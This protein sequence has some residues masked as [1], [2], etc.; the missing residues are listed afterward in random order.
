M[1]TIPDM[2]Y[3]YLVLNTI[4]YFL[5]YLCI[6]H[7]FVTNQFESFLLGIQVE[8][9]SYLLPIQYQNYIEKRTSSVPKLPQKACQFCNNIVSICVSNFLAHILKILILMPKILIFIQNFD[10]YVKK[11]QFVHKKPDSISQ[12]ILIFV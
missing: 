2:Y 6:D 4:L 11:S 7:F 10:L 8:D 5:I 3:M 9:R 12:K 1:S